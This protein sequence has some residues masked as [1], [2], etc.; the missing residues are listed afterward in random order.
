MR[1]LLAMLGVA[2]IAGFATAPAQAYVPTAAAVSADKASDLKAA[3]REQWSYHAWYTREYYVAAILGTANADAAAQRLLK[4]Q[5]DIGNAVGQY[6]GPEAGAKVT[7]LLQDH[8]KIATEV[9]AAAKAGDQAALTEADGRWRQNSMD[10]ARL[11]ADAN[12]DFFPYGETLDLLNQHLDLLSTAVTSF[13]GGDYAQS[14]ADNDVYYQEI[15]M[16]SDYFSDGI[17]GQFPEKFQ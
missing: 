8:I 7:A 14:V 9:V 6:Y 1:L 11:F 17:I 10:L 16:M 4:N 5:E 13:I 3:M 15:L 12:P 2:V